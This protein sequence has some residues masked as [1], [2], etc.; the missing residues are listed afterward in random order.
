MEIGEKFGML[1]VLE[2]LAGKKCK[3]ICDC[4]NETIAYRDNVKRGHTKSCGCLRGTGIVGT[5][6]GKLT[7]VSEV[8][9]GRYEC[10]CD[11]G[12]TEI[13]GY[14]S[15]KGKS[16]H[17]CRKCGDKVR[18]AGRKSSELVNADYVDGTQ[19]S[20]LGKMTSA[21]KSGYVGVNWDK[22]RGKWQASIRF[23]GKKINLGRYDYI[24]DAI[25]ARKAAE[26]EM[27]GHEL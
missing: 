26:R 15:L 9:K 23:K 4:G 3:C 25:D 19:L 27:F 2:M 21:N 16:N 8:S 24:Q 17:Q 22:S 18:D 20:Q 5:K 11:C 7:I 10:R 14:D 6:I 13:R 12:N 1:T